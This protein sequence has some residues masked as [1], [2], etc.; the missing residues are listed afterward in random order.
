LATN[1]LVESL[2][3]VVLDEFLEQEAPMSLTKN[4]E[5]IQAL[6]LDGFDKSFRVRIAIWALGQDLHALHAWCSGVSPALASNGE[7]VAPVRQR[8]ARTVLD[9]FIT[10]P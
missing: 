10:P 2:G 4:H 5:V 8:M 7:I 9:N 3:H 6:V 1:A